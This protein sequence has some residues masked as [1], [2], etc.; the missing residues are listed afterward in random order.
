LELIRQEIEQAANPA[1]RRRGGQRGD[2]GAQVMWTLLEWHDAPAPS[3]AAS[4]RS[5]RAE[6]LGTCAASSP[7][8]VAA[9]E[10]GDGGAAASASRAAPAAMLPVSTT[11]SSADSVGDDPTGEAA[12]AADDDD[13]EGRPCITSRDG[14][15][16]PELWTRRE[17]VSAKKQSDALVHRTICTVRGKA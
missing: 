15:A 7:I 8:P 11:T 12:A 10:G 5:R 16:P 9:G 17:E 2:G 1:S 14:I 13:D 3:V 4:T 6:C